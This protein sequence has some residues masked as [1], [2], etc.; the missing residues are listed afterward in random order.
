MQPTV[1][2]HHPP[3]PVEQQ[4]RHPPSSIAAEQ[5]KSDPR[6]P[7]TVIRHFITVMRSSSSGIRSPSCDR[8]HPT[9]AGIGRARVRGD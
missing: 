8:H 7:I 6:H 5:P 4:N 2:R 1:I 9:P 3:S